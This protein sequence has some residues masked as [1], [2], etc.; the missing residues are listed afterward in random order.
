MLCVRA[1][2]A[3]ARDRHRGISHHVRTVVDLSH[4]RPLVA[5]TPTAVRALPGVRPHPAPRTPPAA[6][7]MGAAGLTVTSMGRG[8]GE[9]PV[10]FD[11]AIAAGA[12]AGGLCDDGGPTAAATRA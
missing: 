4:C 6:E 8:P 10:F 12:L 1:S 3:D 2:G 9:D 5:D 7:L 11:T